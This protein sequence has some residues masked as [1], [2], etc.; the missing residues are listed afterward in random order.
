MDLD[1][2]TGATL[3]LKVD[4]EALTVTFTGE[5]GGESR[6]VTVPIASAA[7]QAFI[8]VCIAGTLVAYAASKQEEQ[9]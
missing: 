8:E 2:V 6:D 3:T 5:I 4:S 9:A 1:T 7:G